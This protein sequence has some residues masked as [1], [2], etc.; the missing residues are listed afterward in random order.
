[1]KMLALAVLGSTV[2]VSEDWKVPFGA[3]LGTFAAHLF[4]T[5]SLRRL[6]TRAIKEHLAESH[7]VPVADPDEI[8]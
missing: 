7:K 6:V 4:N 2:V 1:M 8:D 5:A 3:F